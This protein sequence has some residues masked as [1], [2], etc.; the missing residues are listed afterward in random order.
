MV[1]WYG[2]YARR[3]DSIKRI[4][5][6]ILQ[7][8]DGQSDALRGSIASACGELSTQVGH[9]LADPEPWSSI[10][11]DVNRALRDSYILIGNMGDAC[12]TGRDAEARALIGQVNAA[13][14][15]AAERLAPYGLNP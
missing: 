10:D 11:S 2:T 1:L 5:R 9:V 6:P 15:K 14:A 7:T 3:T 12:R 4:L 13:L 8:Y